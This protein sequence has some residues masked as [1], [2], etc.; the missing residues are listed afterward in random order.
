MSSTNEMTPEEE[1]A[2]FKARINVL[3]D[4]QF[5]LLSGDVRAEIERR[6]TEPHVETAVGGTDKSDVGY[7]PAGLATHVSSDVEVL[8]PTPISPTTPTSPIAA[9]SAELQTDS[10]EE[11]SV[12]YISS[13]STA[14]HHQNPHGAA[15]ALARERNELIHA[16]HASDLTILLEDIEAEAL[17]RAKIQKERAELE[18]QQQQ[19]Q[20]STSA[21]GGKPAKKESANVQAWRSRIAKL[22]DD[23]LAEVTA[24]VFDEIT[25]RKEK[26]ESFLPPRDDLSPK[27]NEA[28]KELAKLPSRELKTLWTIIHEQ[29]KRRNMMP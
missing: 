5:A 3:S 11:P 18:K 21:T 4:V 8:P 19:Q 14:S 10:P 1:R 28:R 27:R 13:N 22:T 29:M 24:D 25:R 9:P 12:H 7:V 20:Q 6:K 2:S 15:S 16:L 23:Q 17:V 26:I